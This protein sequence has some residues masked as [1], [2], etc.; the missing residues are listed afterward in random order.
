VECAGPGLAAPHP[1]AAFALTHR[2][3]KQLASC[4]LDRQLPL[5][6]G[7]HPM[8][9]LMEHL[10][11]VH[12]N[13]RAIVGD[14]RHEIDSFSHLSRDLSGS[15][16]SLSERTE[17]QAERLQQ[18]A[19][20]MTQLAG[21]VEQS[22]QTT[23]EVLQ[24]SGKSA[25]LAERG[26]Q[27]MQKVED[28]VHQLRDSSQQMGQIITT[29]ESIAFQTNIL[30]LNAAVEAARAGE[31]GRGFAV[32]A[33]EVRTLAQRSAEAAK[34]IKRLISGSNDRIHQGAERMQEASATISQAVQ[35]VA[36]VSQLVQEIVETSR[37]QALGIAQVDRAIGEL[38]AVTQ[39]N[40]RMSE[41]SAHSAGHMSSN[42]GVLHRTLEVFRMR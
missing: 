6:P 19:A 4:E 42:A 7:R 16:R 41:V 29:I 21:S 32:V 18:T 36:Q 3:A 38:D 17:L 26:G 30:A 27:A 15:A 9:L 28:M 22:Q 12:F 24:Q 35:S 11:Q 8:A 37:E 2:F 23:E 5:V 25:E 13:L 14:A 33:G 34:E 20:A 31:Q 40:A 1:D 10:H 39:E